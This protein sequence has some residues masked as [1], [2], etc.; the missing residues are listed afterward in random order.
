MDLSFALVLFEASIYAARQPKHTP[1]GGT[2]WSQLNA[3]GKDHRWD[4]YW[5]KVKLN[6]A[7]VQGK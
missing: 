5:D 6:F 4:F 3:S 2:D 1:N 7:D